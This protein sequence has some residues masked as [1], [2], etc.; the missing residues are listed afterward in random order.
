[1][2]VSGNTVIRAVEPHDLDAT[3]RWRNDPRVARPALGRRFP[4]TE[5][6]ERAWFDGLGQGAF[7]THVVWTVADE[8]DKPIGLVQ[9][10]DI[11]WIHRTAYF[12]IWIGPEQQGKG[13]GTRAAQL[14]CRHGFTEL[15]LR[16][17]R[18]EVIAGHDAARAAYR[19]VGFVDEAKLNDA[20]IVGGQPCD[21]HVMVLTSPPA[22]HDRG[23]PLG[24]S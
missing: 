17:I 4:I 7:P 20:V 23:Q 2:Y 14:A 13:H 9:L 22:V 5:V 12:G 3:R 19:K 18:L 11:H 16:Q 6:G 8:S 15:G 10:T 24:E 21:Q 1:V